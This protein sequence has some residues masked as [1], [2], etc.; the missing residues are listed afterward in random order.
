LRQY[1]KRQPI[2][3]STLVLGAGLSLAAGATLFSITTRMIE[4]DAE[5]RFRGMARVAQY[6]ISAH[7]KSYVDVLR[8]A[9]GLFRADPDISAAQFRHYVD[10]LDLKTNFPGIEVM[11]YA[12]VVTDAQ[13]PA[14]EQRLRDR[15]QKLGY[16]HPEQFAIKQREPGSTYTVIVYIEPHPPLWLDKFGMDLEA[17]QYTRLA[18][19]KSRDTN[20]MTASGTRVP[21]LSGPNQHGLAMRLPV[22]RND[23]PISTPEQRRAAYI[24]SVGIGFGVNNLISA[25]VDTLPIKKTRL[26]ITDM[27]PVPAEPGEPP[28]SRLLFDSSYRSGQQ[29][30]PPNDDS[31]RTLH[32]TL[33]I[34]FNQRTWLA[35]FSIPRMGLYTDFDAFYPWIAAIAGG[36]STALLYALF[37]TLAASRRRAIELAEEMTQELRESKARLQISHEKLRRLAAHTEQIKEGERKRIAREIHDDLGQSLLALRIDA[38][39]LTSRTRERHGHLHARAQATLRQIDATIRSVRHIINDLRPNVLDLGLNAA[40]DWQVA[41]FKNRTGIA[42]FLS[43]DDTELRVDDRC[44]TA[45]FR[46]LQESLNNIARHAKATEVHIELRLRENML[47][48]SI[49]DN[50][51]GLQPD[52][53]NRQGSFGLVGIE[54]RVTILGGTFSINSFPGGGTLLQV[55]VPIAQAEAR[56]RRP[57]EPSPLPI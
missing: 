15:L 56:E 44:A 17:R 14:Q 13:R 41:D 12:K 32:V 43:D 1:F 31:F 6:N 23:M 16:P 25:V 27:T 33:P 48:M 42:C 20:T 40:V 3:P 57:A 30:R 26:V 38:E 55:R 2:S 10:Q 21:I 18:L 28:Q 5:Q 50:G 47:S 37:E 45:F 39:M 29:A 11:N 36:L 52:S 54:E 22:Y 46:I 4:S 9:A 34:E 53:R 49:H 8:G 35:D 7:I 24:G 19:A 51:I